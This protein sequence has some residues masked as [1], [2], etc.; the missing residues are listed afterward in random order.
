[1][2]MRPPAHVVRSG[3]LPPRRDARPSLYTCQPTTRIGQASA[4]S[5]ADGDPGAATPIGSPRLP[6]RAGPRPRVLVASREPLPRRPTPRAPEPRHTT[7]VHR[8]D[9][10]EHEEDADRG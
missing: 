5:T 1:M 9:R 8:R 4:V 2:Y 3:S 10:H 7:P 6:W